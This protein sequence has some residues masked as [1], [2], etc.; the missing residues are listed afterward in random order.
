MSVSWDE[1]AAIISDGSVE[2]LARLERNDETLN[3]YREF[4]AQL[5]TEWA[6]V[7]DYLIATVFSEFSQVSFQE[8]GKKRA[9]LHA[10]D[11]K[12]AKVWRKND[13]PYNFEHEVTHYCLWSSVP[14]SQEEIMLEITTQF[15]PDQHDRLFF[16][17]PPSLQSIRDLWHCHVMIRPKLQ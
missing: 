17:N 14:L 2:K 13:F 7:T 4:R 11:Q 3:S 10:H 6:T 8:D 9:E 5:K 1:A 16:I 15:N 12:K